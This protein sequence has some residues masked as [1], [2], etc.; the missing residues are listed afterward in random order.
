MI[1]KGEDLLIWSIVLLWY[2]TEFLFC[3]W[4]TNVLIVLK[5]RAFI[6]PNTFTLSS[7]QVFI[8]IQRWDNFCPRSNR[9]A[10]ARW[11]WP[12]SWNQNFSHVI[13]SPCLLH[14]EAINRIDCL[15]K[16]SVS[17]TIT[18]SSASVPFGGRLALRTNPAKPERCQRPW[19]TASRWKSS[20]RERT[21]HP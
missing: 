21:S 1:R 11:K 18:P 19:Q 10:L 7:L 5:S 2:S 20:H 17:S 16:V 13:C 14:H 12:L 15:Q 3:C 4:F 8:T 9:E 6:E